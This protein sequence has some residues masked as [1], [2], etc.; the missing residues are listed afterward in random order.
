MS[1]KVIWQQ[2][3]NTPEV[4]ILLPFC[5][6]NSAYDQYFKETAL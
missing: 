6:H 2:F 1:K 4:Y 5:N 3:G